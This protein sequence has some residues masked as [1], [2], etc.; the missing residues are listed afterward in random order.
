MPSLA[1]IA[2][3]GN[4]HWGAAAQLEGVWGVGRDVMRYPVLLQIRRRGPDQFLA[5]FRIDAQQLADLAVVI[6]QCGIVPAVRGM[7]RQIHRG[8]P[9]GRGQSRL[10]RRGASQIGPVADAKSVL[11]GP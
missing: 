3:A 8:N 4:F 2:G 11:T 6:R 5:P 1:P 10:R 9:A 7:A